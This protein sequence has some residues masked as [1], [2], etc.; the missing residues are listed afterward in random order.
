M[1][2]LSALVAIEMVI[3]QLLDWV[4]LWALCINPQKQTL[5]K[6]YYATAALIKCIAVASR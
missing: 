6:K 2:M 3:V 4:G 1:S 5:A